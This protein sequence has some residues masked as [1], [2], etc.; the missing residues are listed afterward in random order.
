MDTHLT[1]GATAG[2]GD[3]GGGCSTKSGMSSSIS[4]TGSRRGSVRD[5][6]RDGESVR[7]LLSREGEDG[8]GIE[9]LS[10]PRRSPLTQ[11]RA[12]T[13]E[14]FNDQQDQ[15][16]DNTQPAV[17]VTSD[18]ETTVLGEAT[19]VMMTSV[20]VRKASSV[21]SPAH[22]ITSPGRRPSRGTPPDRASSGGGGET[23]AS[24]IAH[25]E[26]AAATNAAAA[27]AAAGSPT[28]SSGCGGGSGRRSPVAVARQQQQRGP[29]TS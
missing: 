2:P 7:S 27:A 25:Y 8:R 5:T 21:L 23:V 26:T 28:A 22:A 10:T 9:S 20:E 18:H 4:I 12:L 15:E 29:G 1:A 24:L 17:T 3:A 14:A 13:A 11:R 6:S 16:K 19:A